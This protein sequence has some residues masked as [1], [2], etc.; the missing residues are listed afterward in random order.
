MPRRGYNLLLDLRPGGA[1]KVFLFLLVGTYLFI[2]YKF[3]ILSL[4]FFITTIIYFP[5]DIKA[6]A[7]QGDTGANMQGIVLGILF[8]KFS[9]TI[10]VITVV[11]LLL[12]NLYSEKK[13]ITVLI[14]DNKFLNYIDMLGRD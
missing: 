3:Q 14:R 4:A 9:L 10:R 1:S 5:L 13:S 12:I 6:K 11:L 2:P 8:I 7:M